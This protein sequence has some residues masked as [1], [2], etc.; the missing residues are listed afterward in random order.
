MFKHQHIYIIIMENEFFPY[1]QIVSW[2]YKEHRG[3]KYFKTKKLAKE[4]ARVYCPSVYKII[5]W[6]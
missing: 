4:Y 3:A 2:D 5:K 6:R 1:L